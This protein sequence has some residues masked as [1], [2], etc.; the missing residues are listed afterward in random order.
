[1]E[2]CPADHDSAHSD[3]LHDRHRGENACPPDLG[4]NVLD[5]GCFL[6]CGKFARNGPAGASRDGAQ[7][8]LDTEIVYFDY[9]S[10][11]FVWKL[12]PD[13][14]DMMIVPDALMDIFGLLNIRVDV[15]SP[16]REGL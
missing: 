7:M 8:F 16:L 9:N 1:M 13:I 6:G 15:K 5:D 12:M 11:D 3:R 14:V 4:D 2:G 10:I